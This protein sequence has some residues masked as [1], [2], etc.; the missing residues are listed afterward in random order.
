M[1][2]NKLLFSIV[3]G[4]NPMIELLKQRKS[5]LTV[6]EV[7][8]ILSLSEREIYK[9]AASN[10]IPHF[11]IG[12]SVRFDSESLVGWLESRMLTPSDRRLPSSARPRH[13]RLSS[14]A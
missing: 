2:A 4:G 8:E 11:R 1:N 3:N 7:A 10:R 14:I 5:A 9:L 12:A 13:E 6:R